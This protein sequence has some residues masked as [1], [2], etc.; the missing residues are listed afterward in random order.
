MKSSVSILH[1]TF[2]LNGLWNAWA[3]SFKLMIHNPSLFKLLN[4]IIRVVNKRG[5]YLPNHI[6]DLSNYPP[7]A[8]SEPL[9]SLVHSFKGIQ[10]QRHSSK[11]TFAYHRNVITVMSFSCWLS[12]ASSSRDEGATTTPAN[13]HCAP[14]K[15][16]VKCQQAPVISSSEKGAGRMA[17]WWY[18]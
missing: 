7:Q 10:R 4:H 17:V 1:T 18:T 11:Q 2:K 13:K 9:L 5:S 8:A 15:V 3:S 12:M 6:F 16:K 14:T